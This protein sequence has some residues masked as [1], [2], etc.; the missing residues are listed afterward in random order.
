VHN[1]TF[2]QFVLLAKRFSCTSS[3]S[4]NPISQYLKAMSSTSISTTK[5]TRKELTSEERSEIVGAYKCGIRPATIAR[6]L[7]VPSSTVYD[8]I[9]RYKK[10]GSP[11]TKVRP[12]RPPSLTQR[13]QRVVQRVVLA[14]RHRPLRE[15]TNEVNASLS[16]NLHQK[17]I[18]KYMGKAGFSSHPA[19]KKP[20]LR[21]KTSKSGSRGVR[22]AER[23][24]R[25]GRM[26]SLATSRPSPSSITMGEEKY[27]AELGSDTTPTAWCR[28]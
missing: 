4:S 15:I 2:C 19:C 8:T 14:R 6:T 3:Y 1:A 13:D 7:G 18:R 26:R 24:T 9:A 20:L 21:K 22:S 12:G 17:T 5:E 23:G 25:S 16:A 10:T 11:Q 27:G 28:L